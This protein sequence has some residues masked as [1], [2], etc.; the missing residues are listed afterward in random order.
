MFLIGNELQNG[1]LPNV[2]ILERF[3]KYFDAKNIDPS[4]SRQE[5]KQVSFEAQGKINVVGLGLL[6]L[7]E[8]V[9]ELVT[10]I[11]I[12]HSTAWEMTLGPFFG[13]TTQFGPAFA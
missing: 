6:K 11:E 13:Q 8:K 1:V 7:D 10:D 5:R 3:N 12:S 4:T 9:G 2:D